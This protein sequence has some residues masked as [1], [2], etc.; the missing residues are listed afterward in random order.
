MW[1]ESIR[2]YTFFIKKHCEMTDMHAGCLCVGEKLERE[3][4]QKQGYFCFV[5]TSM[6]WSDNASASMVFQI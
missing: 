1:L 3:L 5:A 2:R 6:L 4:I